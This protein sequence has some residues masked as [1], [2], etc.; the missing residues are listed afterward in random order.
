MILEL[1][2]FKG[3]NV[4][5]FEKIFQLYCFCVSL[6]LRERK[7]PFNKSL[8]GKK[9]FNLVDVLFLSLVMQLCQSSL[10]RFDFDKFKCLLWSAVFEKSCSVT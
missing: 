3:N 10:K 9:T 7:K 8:K 6:C 5:G 4:T 2:N 1:D